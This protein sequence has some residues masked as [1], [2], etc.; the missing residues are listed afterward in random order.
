[1]LVYVV[2]RFFNQY[3]NVFKLGLIDYIYY[4]YIYLEMV[5]L[6]MNIECGCDIY[7]CFV[8]IVMKIK[9]LFD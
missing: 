2:V 6:Q 1:M 5:V 4:I 9:Y 3:I 8:K 7:I